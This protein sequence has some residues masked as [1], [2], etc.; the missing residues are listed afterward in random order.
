MYS[1]AIIMHPTVH[2]Y[3]IHV[4][5]QKWFQR[6]HIVVRLECARNHKRCARVENHNVSKCDTV[7]VIVYQ[8]YSHSEPRANVLIAAV[9]P[10]V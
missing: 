2:V 6:C 1:I 7:T 5:I 10:L 4:I 9:N 8:L 3:I